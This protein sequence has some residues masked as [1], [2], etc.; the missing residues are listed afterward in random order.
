LSSIEETVNSVFMGLRGPLPSSLQ[1]YVLAL[2]RRGELATLEEGATIASVSRSRV[3]AWLRVAGIDWKRSRLAFVA[4]HRTRAAAQ[5][6]GITLRRPSKR[7]LRL[8]GERA[9]REWDQRHAQK[10]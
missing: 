10:P 2:Y 6:E 4:R 3:L 1:A 7:M 5:A 9:K 8:I